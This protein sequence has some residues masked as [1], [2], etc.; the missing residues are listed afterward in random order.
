M[1]D[2][3]NNEDAY[4]AKS[5][6]RLTWLLEGQTVEWCRQDNDH[7]LTIKFA[8]GPILYVD[9]SGSGQRELELSIVSSNDCDPEWDTHSESADAPPPERRRE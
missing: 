9:I 1:P 3:D 8:K 2:A 4:F 5:S 7:N 6:A